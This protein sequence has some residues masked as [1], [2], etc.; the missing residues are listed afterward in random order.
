VARARRWSAA[1]TAKVTVLCGVGHVT[2]SV[3]LALLALTLGVELFTRLGGRLEAVAGVLLIGFGLAYAVWGLRRATRGRLHTHGDGERD[4]SRLT[5]GSLFFLFTADPCVAVIPLLLASVS[6]GW[7]R[8]LF[9]ILTY[10]TAMLATMLALV[11]PARA[12]LARFR[13]HWIDH[14]GDAAAGICIALV[15]IAVT[16]LGW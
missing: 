2:G 5:A 10:E 16:L 4:P 11:L 15:G 8:T 13:M 7:A 12:G 1:R 14:W 3:A 6:L 9:V